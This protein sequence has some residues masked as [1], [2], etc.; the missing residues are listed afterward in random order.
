MMQECMTQP[1][2]IV[3]IFNLTVTQLVI[4]GAYIF[5]FAPT[6]GVGQK[7]ELL[8]GWGENMMIY[9]EKTRI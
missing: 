7:Y 1:G 3:V 6:R 4:T 8:V 5:H 9:Q 2:R